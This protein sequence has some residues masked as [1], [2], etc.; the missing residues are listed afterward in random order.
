[1]AMMIKVGAL[2]R[3]HKAQNPRVIAV[4]LL[5]KSAP[6]SVLA[7]HVVVVYTDFSLFAEKLLH[8]NI[9]YVFCLLIN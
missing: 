6:V 4:D 3:A 8:P 1:M 5:A 9:K 7:V 2:K